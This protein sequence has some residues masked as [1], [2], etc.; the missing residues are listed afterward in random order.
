[1]GDSLTHR[2]S[3]A[4]VLLAAACV[5]G[6]AP[7]Q[8][9]PLT[10]TSS[11]DA[12]YAR[13]VA[14]LA[15]SDL[16]ADLRRALEAGPALDAADVREL[17][18]RWRAAAGP[19]TGDEWLLVAHLWQQAGVA[20]SAL[21]AFRRAV[22]RGGTPSGLLSLEV[23]RTALTQGSPETGAK[24]YWKGCEWASP[25]VLAEY[26]RDFAAVATPD[27][28][29]AWTAAAALSANIRNAASCAVLRRG[30]ARRASRSGLS[31][32]GRLAVHYRRLR[33]ARKRYFL[34]GGHLRLGPNTR[35]L[36]TQVGRTGDVGLDDRGIIYVRLGEPDRTASFGG[37]VG[38]VHQAYI[39][40]GESAGEPPD[41][42]TLN[43]V[44]VLPDLQI[45]AACYQPNESWAYDYPGGTRVFH[46]SPLEGTAN[47]WLI[48]N[49]AD[50]YRCGDPDSWGGTTVTP[51]TSIGNS[52]EDVS[53]IAW[54]VLGDLYMSRVGLDSRYGTIAQR[55]WSSGPNSLSDLY[56]GLKSRNGL[57]FRAELTEERQQ[58]YELAHQTLT[59]IT[60]RPNVRA[61][62]PLAFE[63]LQFRSQ[64]IDGQTRTRVWV[65]VVADG[66][67]LRADR[68]A[69]GIYKYRVIGTLSLVDERGEIHQRS[70]TF[71][72]TAERELNDDAGLP[73]RLSVDVP[74]GA[75]SY[76][77]ALRDAHDSRVPPA[78]N[79]RADSLTVRRY[80][81]QLPELSDIAVAP[82]SGGAWS[83]TDGVRLPITPLHQ[84]NASGNAWLYFE[85]YGL[86]PTGG[87][88]VEV[89][90]EP[91]EDGEPF[92]LTYHGAA[93][94]TREETLQ[95]LLRLDLTNSRPGTYDARVA[96]TDAEGRTSLPL[97]IVLERAEP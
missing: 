87:Y 51:A 59:T 22:A 75:Y 29:S 71:S 4:A 25:G 46:F 31:V 37:N 90:L 13:T 24:V 19:A 67:K 69:Y 39:P 73:V 92:T 83:P 34:V 82:D 79:W 97:V 30:W 5:L 88:E 42:L 60:D 43:M 18:A 11:A 41:S 86:S 72:L 95:R 80:A 55:A 3:K 58:N 23:A 66:S 1:M 62:V 63:V 16:Q 74:P 78:G 85:A 81:A 14:S 94:A 49:L 56:E 96:I 48:E 52:I 50:L 57:S 15:S 53:T 27:E 8:Q 68:G 32:P 12:P 38:S 84:T 44:N 35:L 21:D 54:I 28:D 65:N 2:T 91:R 89:Q 7:P 26:W 47:W 10:D 20:D 70:A 64:P 93:P 77:F 17:L 40:G 9:T 33:E 45:S 76:T 61:I 36:S 6:A